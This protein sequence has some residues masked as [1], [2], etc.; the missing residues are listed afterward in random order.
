[1]VMILKKIYILILSLLL[2]ILT[3]SCVSAGWF[4][5]GDDSADD[6]PENIT[7]I[8]EFTEGLRGIH[9]DDGSVNTHYTIKGVFKGLPNNV[10]GYDLIISLYDKNGKLMKKDEGHS[11][12]SIAKSSKKSEI[13]TLGIISTYDKKIID[14]KYI[15]LT[16]YD[17]NGEIVFDKNIT[18]TIEN[19][20][21]NY[22][23]IEDDHPTNSASSSSSSSDK[24]HYWWSDEPDPILSMEY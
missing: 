20:Q 10:E 21:T 2:V 19:L 5:W 1:M 9:E 18:F 4:G 8:K 22:F 3:M 12:D 14:A 16:I 24:Y 13:S 17:D 7:L 11:M 15:E 23:T 6:V